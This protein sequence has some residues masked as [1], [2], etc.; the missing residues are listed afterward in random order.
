MLSRTKD[1]AVHVGPS[2]QLLP[3]KELLNFQPEPSI[4]FQNR[5]LL[6]VLVVFMEM[7]DV[8]EDGWMNVIDNGI[9][10][11]SSYPYTGKDG[12]CRYTTPR[13][14][15]SSFVDVDELSES[16]LLAAIA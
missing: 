9:T 15:I 4:T 10:T 12:S 6:I 1:H 8:M 3:L 16:A 13:V 14:G 2:Q 11:Q 5:N 7:R